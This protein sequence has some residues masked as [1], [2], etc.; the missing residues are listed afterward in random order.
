MS[1]REDMNTTLEQPALAF[2]S[3]A[4]FT[5]ALLTSEGGD[6]LAE[7]LGVIGEQ[8]AA[9]SIHM[10][11][12][13]ASSGDT[14]ERV[15]SWPTDVEDTA[16]TC[17]SVSVL[18]SE[19]EAR[20][21]L[22]DAVEMPNDM[23][24]RHTMNQ[25][26]ELGLCWAPMMSKGDLTGVLCARRERSRG[27]WTEA[28]L[29][30]MRATASVI[31]TWTQRMEEAKEALER[32]GELG[33]ILTHIEE[34]VFKTDASGQ[35]TYLNNSWER[36]LD[37]EPSACVGHSLVEYVDPLDHSGLVSRF[38]PLLRE[39]VTFCRMKLRLL[40]SS[41]AQRWVELFAR[42]IYS[43]D[44]VFLGATGTL[45]DFSE[46]RWEQK[47]RREHA[48]DEGMRGF[49]S[50]LSHELNNILQVTLV[51]LELARGD[52]EAII[53][54]AP[55]KDDPLVDV[56][57]GLE[58]VRQVSAELNA[59]AQGSHTNALVGMSRAID[60]AVER[61]RALAPTAKVEV[62]LP[63]M[64]WRGK[65]DERQI[66][67]A[68]EHLVLNAMESSS[69]PQVN[70][71]ALNVNVSALDVGVTE[72][73]MLPGDYAC[74]LVRDDG[75][76]MS[77]NTLERA[78]EPF[79]TFKPGRRGMGLSVAR[80]V[81]SSHNGALI[82]RTTP[83]LGTSAAFYIPRHPE[84]SVAGSP[85]PF[86]KRSGKKILLAD[87]EPRVRTTLSKALRREGYDVTSVE[88]GAT[89]LAKLAGDDSYDLAIFDY[90]MPGLHGLPMLELVRARYED[91]PILV[92]TG[93][94]LG[95]QS[96]TRAFH[97]VPVLLKPYSVSQIKALLMELLS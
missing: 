89:A 20:L 3:V 85:S 47:L 43:E 71:S 78:W 11:S 37:L 82:M 30:L 6:S 93:D 59:F 65:G 63:G 87:D 92:C 7:A 12:L 26:D 28:E 76:G 57:A 52:L 2:S 32:A 39:E 83:G 4:T 62:E 50:K 44:G 74:V 24:T 46:E 67:L 13:Q 25:Q 73:G 96:V 77:S 60:S 34:A 55:L 27:V 66:A 15:S 9:H 91:L 68:L 81:A 21:R 36:L 64:L 14:L 49:A 10:W 97:D 19:I 75:H 94:R 5:E 56:H 33:Q 1:G 80:A 79:E 58:R 69:D 88:D 86:Y 8:L 61:A 41:K 23:R 38:L 42:R 17:I 54:E 70:V 72:H 90:I 29:S 18:P 48:R 22:G 53:G 40:N 95:A 51:S 31:S 84:S 35:I 16:P 45:R